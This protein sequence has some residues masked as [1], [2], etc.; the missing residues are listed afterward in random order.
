VLSP[1]AR[2]YHDPW[3]ALRAATAAATNGLTLAPSTAARL[4]A[5]QLP[6]AE[7]W[8]DHP[9]RLLVRLLASGPDLLPVWEEL[10][11]CGLV[12]QWLPEWAGI[13]LRVSESAVHRFTVDRHLVETCVEASRLMREVAR[14]DLLVVAA[15][16]HDLGKHD[17][18]GDHSAVG[19]PMAERIALRWGFAAADA[20]TVALLVRHHLLLHETAVRRDIDD[21]VTL[22]RVAALVADDTTLDL[23]AA[24]S[25]ADAR[26]AAPAAWT[27]WRAELVRRLVS[28]L[29]ATLAEGRPVSAAGLPLDDAGDRVIP[30]WAAALGDGEVRMLVEPQA[31]G[32]RVLVAAADR[33]G[34]LA[35]VSGALATGGL[36]V[37]A[38]RAAVHGGT[39]V[40]TWDVESADV[41]Q[42]RLRLRLDRV[43][44][45]S[46]DLPARLGA[47]GPA[48][49]RP[50]SHSASGDFCPARGG[51][52]VRLLSA[53]SSSA[54]V[55]EIRAADR[56]GLVWRLC[57]ALADS[58]VEVRSAHLETLGPQAEDVVYVT[59]R[60][61]RALGAERA[62]QVRAAVQ[63]ALTDGPDDLG[64]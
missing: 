59:E 3:L 54:T 6:L 64:G 34:L 37:R 2:P 51:V 39:A 27:S 63:L 21:P 30:A 45:G 55:L 62:E 33:A 17:Q 57:R 25:E 19:A 41:D 11:Q 9:R 50:L 24:L 43:L 26:A 14:P 4:A 35:D 56:P 58:E 47:A 12:D 40:S 15:L 5:S 13:R 1:H 60:G 23:L 8:P 18:G 29:R 52:R 28:A 48:S 10:D 7:T 46:V 20:H 16:L 32:T 49:R 38:A 53:V 42:A 31:D 36:T 22:G 44:D 61:G